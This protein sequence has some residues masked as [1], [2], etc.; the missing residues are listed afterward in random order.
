MSRFV[1]Y[2]DRQVVP[3]L[4]PL[5]TAS[6]LGDLTPIEINSKPKLYSPTRHEVKKIE[7]EFYKELPYAI[8]LISS[9]LAIKDYESSEVK[10]ASKFILKNSESNK[11][12]IEI[13]EKIL[14]INAKKNEINLI[15]IVDDNEIIGKI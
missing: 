8:E 12:I 10:N 2:K 7:W 9:A 14:N 11:Y 3:R 15:D 1:D 6:F 4:I 13:A 5:M